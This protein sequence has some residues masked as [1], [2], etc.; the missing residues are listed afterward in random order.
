MIGGG[1]YKIVGDRVV[2][3]ETD[4]RQVIQS[5]VTATQAVVAAPPTTLRATD[6]EKEAV[7]RCVIG[8]AVVIAIIAT[9]WV[10]YSHLLTISMRSSGAVKSLAAV[11]RLT[12]QG[13]TDA[14][15]PTSR[16]GTC[17]GGHA[18]DSHRA[19]SRKARKGSSCVSRSTDGYGNGK[20]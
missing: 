5:D 19:R 2:P 6:P 15:A 11:P 7:R 8:V 14:G 4:L 10:I 20:A 1:R 9:G 12:G 3:S 18:S 16:G 17:S 13:D